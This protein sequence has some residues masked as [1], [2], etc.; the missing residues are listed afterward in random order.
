LLG[1]GCD[2]LFQGADARSFLSPP[3]CMAF[4]ILTFLSAAPV[5]TVWLQLSFLSVDFPSAFGPFLFVELRPGY[6]GVTTP[7][8]TCPPSQFNGDLMRPFN[9]PHSLSSFWKSRPPRGHGTSSLFDELSPV[10]PRWSAFGGFSPRSDYNRCVLIHD[11]ISSRDSS[12]FP[13]CR[14]GP[15]ELTLAEPFPLVEPQPPEPS[16]GIWLFPPSIN[17]R[18]FV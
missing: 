8:L 9:V 7:L 5:G 12:S 10:P 4:K 15:G 2:T 16:V 6:V 11:G 13:F 14:L 17:V 3:L 18:C 1:G